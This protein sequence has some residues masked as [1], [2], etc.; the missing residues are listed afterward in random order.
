ME[1]QVWATGVSWSLLNAILNSIFTQSLNSWLHTSGPDGILHCKPHHSPHLYSQCV[2]HLQ[3]GS[4]KNRTHFH[5]TSTLV[6]GLYGQL[7]WVNAPVQISLQISMEC[8]TW[9]YVAVGIIMVRCKFQRRLVKTPASTSTSQMHFTEYCVCSSFKK[10]AI[11]GPC[12]ATRVV[13]LQ[14]RSCQPTCHGLGR[15]PRLGCYWLAGNGAGYDHLG[16]PGLTCDPEA[17]AASLYPERPETSRALTS[18]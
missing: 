1:V 7:M 2:T 10:G 6:S 11:N 18:Y 15:H 3:L 8:R 14:C 12:K 16:Q 9:K 13:S 17:L 4:L 5:R